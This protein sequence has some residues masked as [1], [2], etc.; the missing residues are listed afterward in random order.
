MTIHLSSH[1]RHS[2]MQLL[3]VHCALYFSRN[4][5]S[6]KN[7]VTEISPLKKI[8]GLER[9][10]SSCLL[11]TSTGLRECFMAIINCPA[12]PKALALILLHPFRKVSPLDFLHCHRSSTSDKLVDSK[13][14][15]WFSW[16]DAPGQFLRPVH[17]TPTSDSS[18]MF[19]KTWLAKCTSYHHECRQEHYNRRKRSVPHRLIN[20]GSVEDPSLRLVNINPSEADD[21]SLQYVA[22]SYCWGSGNTY[23]ATKA[24]YT[25]M[26]KSID[27]RILPQTLRD[28]IWVTRRLG[29]KY[30]WIDS[31]C[32]FQDDRDDWA[33][34]SA[35][36]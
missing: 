10:L 18:I 26:T 31:L 6:D 32:I 25:S 1:S 20:V 11:R 3:R 14:P 12:L 23:L 17:R 13:P 33:R 2:K 35:K 16:S 28:A 34:Q 29:L 19:I 7:D 27:E 9:C 21:D 5:S 4:M 24:N 30:I 22:L 36:M 8:F 15:P